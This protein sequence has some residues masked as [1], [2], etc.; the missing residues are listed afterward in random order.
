M[1]TRSW[2]DDSG[3]TR[4]KTECKLN[5]IQIL[6]PKNAQIITGSSGYDEIPD[7]TDDASVISRKND[8][9]EKFFATINAGEGKEDTIEGKSKAG[10]GG[11][12]QG[13]DYSDPAT[14][15]NKKSKYR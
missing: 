2:V 3:E 6:T 11:T 10:S 9:K 15:S 12:G 13:I 7:Y 5:D 8:S 4:Y 14:T 1:R